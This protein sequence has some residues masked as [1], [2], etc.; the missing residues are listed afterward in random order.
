MGFDESPKETKGG[1]Q[2]GITHSGEEKVNKK[3]S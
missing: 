2:E 3:D 1:L